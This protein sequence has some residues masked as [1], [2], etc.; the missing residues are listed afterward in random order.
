MSSNWNNVSWKIIKKSKNFFYE[1][2]LLRLNCN[3][4]KKILKWKSIL[5]FNKT[6]E[7][8]AAWYRS[9]YESPKNIDKVTIQ[10]IKEYQ[11]LLIK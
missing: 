10:Q 6:T 4:A 11:R 1:S 3:K 8:V 2:G 5:N 7:M 9:Y